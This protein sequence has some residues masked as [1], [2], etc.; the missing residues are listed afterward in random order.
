MA[1]TKKLTAVPFTAIKLH[2]AFWAPRID[3]NRR[4]TLPAEYEMCETTGRI[5]AFDMKWKKGQ[6]NPPH[7]FWDSD[8]AKWIEAAAYSLATHPDPALDQLLDEVIARIVKGQAKD[9]YFN[10]H[11]IPFERAKL[12]KRFTNLRDA[13]ELYCAG[14]MFEAAVAHF[15]ATGKRSLLNAMCKYADYIDSVF[16][17]GAGKLRGYCGHQEIELALVKLYHVTENKRYLKLAQYFVDERGHGKVGSKSPKPGRDH[18]YDVEALARGQ[19]PNNFHFARNK[20]A[21]TRYEYNQSHMPVR[22]M[23]VVTGH[24]VRAVYLYCAMADIANETG[25][26]TLLKACERLWHSIVDERM[27]LTGGIGPSASNEGFT[28]AYDLPDETAYAETCASVAMVFWGH[29]MLQFDANGHYADVMERCL[30]NGSLSGVSLD[31][32]GFFYD[33][34]LASAGHHHRQGWFDCACCPPNIARLIASVGSYFY[35][36][37]AD[38][39]WA[40]LYASNT[41]EVT[42]GNSPVTIEQTANYPWDGKIELKLK[43]PKVKKFAVNLRIPGWCKNYT[44]K[45]NGQSHR[46]ASH[47]SMANGQ[48]KKGYLKLQQTWQDGDTITLNLDMPV[49]FVQANPVVRQLI[50]RVAM[51][52]GPLVYCLEGVDNKIAPLDRVM[53]SP[54][55]PFTAEFKPKLLGGVTVLRGQALLQDSQWGK[56]LYATVDPSK[57]HLKQ[58]TVD[59]IAI[60][61][62]TWDNRAPGEMRVWLR[63]AV[64]E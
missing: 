38:G 59:V 51:Q 56:Q 54:E 5:D 8:V 57:T 32:K 49:Q 29:R 46:E 21:T 23:S 36:T 2:D 41:V 44:V 3:I 6:P 39:L 18:Y 63:E 24:A 45:I 42:L 20:P 22:E 15:Q 55:T 43:L 48:L 11:Y 30:F 47:S 40:H 9:G 17:V 26:E 53:L 7:I 34:P 16:G 37:S 14:H 4:Q 50:G 52:R 31:G 60:P 64:N 33:N 58:K 19:N 12:D 25:D 1:V 28:Y 35:S 13:H 10:S 61:Y 62:C 27:Y